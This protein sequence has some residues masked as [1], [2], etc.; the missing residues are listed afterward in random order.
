MSKDIGA[1][2]ARLG[3]VVTRNREVR[4]SI[5]L[6]AH[7]SVSNISILFARVLLTSPRFHTIVQLNSSRLAL[8][9]EQ[10]RIFFEE[11]SIEYLQ[12]E[13]TT[14]ILA[15]LAPCSRTR[16][17]EMA[18]VAYYQKAG[19]L[20]FSAAGYHMPPDF[21]GWMRVSFAVGPERLSVAIKRLKTAY[22]AYMSRESSRDAL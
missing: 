1:T 11:N 8:A 10:I 4:D 14:F 3:C 17:D 9:Y 6:V 22:Q 2:G 12:C 16:D 15:R 19:I 20:F 18:A 13:A 7:T 21:R 5:A